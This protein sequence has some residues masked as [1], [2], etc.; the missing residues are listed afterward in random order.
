MSDAG[1]ENTVLF[2]LRNLCLAITITNRSIQNNTFNEIIINIFHFSDAQ[3]AEDSYEGGVEKLETAVEN[4]N[5]R[6]AR[7]LAEYSASQ[8]K[9]KQ[10]LAKLELK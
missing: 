9:L 5:L 6:L 3:Q 10:R 1:F 7:L 8:A 2:F 4:L